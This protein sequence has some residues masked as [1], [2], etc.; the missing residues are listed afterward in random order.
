MNTYSQLEYSKFPTRWS[1]GGA[2]VAA[3]GGNNADYF[4][5]VKENH[6]T[7]STGYHICLHLIKA[8]RWKTILANATFRKNHLQLNEHSYQTKKPKPDKKLKKGC[9]IIYCL[10]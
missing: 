2:A 10:H 6:E 8:M 9:S 5:A 7:W 4:I 1:F 3:F